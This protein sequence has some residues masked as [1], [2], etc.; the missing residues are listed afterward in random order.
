MIQY[1][2]GIVKYLNFSSN[3]AHPGNVLESFTASYSKESSY[4]TR[5]AFRI[6]SDRRLV[7]Y[8]DR[9]SIFEKHKN[10]CQETARRQKA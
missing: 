8:L 4:Y 2:L 9:E 10:E 3:S 1:L 7:V 5:V 6:A